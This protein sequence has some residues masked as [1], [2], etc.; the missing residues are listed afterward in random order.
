MSRETETLEILDRKMAELSSFLSPSEIFRAL[1]EGTISGAPR[2]AVFLLRE[3]RWKGWNSIGYPTAAAQ[4][5]RQTVAPADS[6]WLSALASEEDVRWRSLTAGEAVPDFGQPHAADSVG[7]PVRVGGKAVAILIAERGSREA[8][9]S[10]A[11]L[12]ILCQAARLR[13][14][15]I[16]KREKQHGENQASPRGRKNPFR[17]RHDCP[18]TA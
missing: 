14:S 2:A 8:P 3:G 7:L 5:L 10:P 13:L 6:G 12:S 15:W 9:W 4:S 1:L 18:A 11:A 16:V 17:E